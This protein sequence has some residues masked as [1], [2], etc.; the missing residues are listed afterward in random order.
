LPK[1]IQHFKS[2]QT[3]Y[4]KATDCMLLTNLTLTGPGRRYEYPRAMYLESQGLNELGQ[5]T[6]NTTV[7][8]ATVLLNKTNPRRGSPLRMIV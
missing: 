7:F 5:V 8:R 3:F 4:L 6:P 1:R 2:V